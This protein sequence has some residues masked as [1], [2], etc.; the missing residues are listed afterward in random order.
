MSALSKLEMSSKPPLGKY[1]RR[2]VV[3]PQ[4]LFNPHRVNVVEIPSNL[5]DEPVVVAAT[6]RMGDGMSV[7]FTESLES[8]EAP[9]SS[10]STFFT[11]D[12]CQISKNMFED[13][14][15]S[16]HELEVMSGRIPDADASLVQDYGDISKTEDTEVS[17]ATECSVSSVSQVSSDIFDEEFTIPEEI[18]SIRA[19]TIPIKHESLSVITEVS[20]PVSLST[21]NS[22][23]FYNESSEISKIVNMSTSAYERL[24]KVSSP[25][26]NEVNTRDRSYECLTSIEH[27]LEKMKG[28]I[29]EDTAAET[30]ELYFADEN[31]TEANF[32][33]AS[34][35]K[36]KIRP[37]TC[38]RHDVKGRDF[39]C[40]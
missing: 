5:H 16:P 32:A 38:A 6:K 25:I 33:K 11:S 10:E 29:M 1:Y 34:K 36:Q 14:F 27:S 18:E 31:K 8:H 15:L 20:E 21:E 39:F 3:V 23:S 17:T 2:I 19:L 9:R 24:N 12:V 40:T 28:L 35:I 7:Q 22:T 4:G 13:G 26:L 37:L 30:E